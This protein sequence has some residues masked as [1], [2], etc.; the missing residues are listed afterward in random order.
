MKHAISRSLEKYGVSSELFKKSGWEIREIRVWRFGGMILTGK[1]KYWEKNIIQRGG[2]WMNEYGALVEWYWLTGGTE[3]LAEK[4]YTASVV[5]EWMS[6]QNWWNDTDR[7]NW[8]TGRKTLYSVGDRWMNEYGAL[9]EW[10]WQGKNEVI[11][12]KHYTASVVDEWMSMGHWW[13]DTDRGK[14]K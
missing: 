8:S 4:H 7:G 14:L 1:L 2:R 3:V 13:N 11:G 5:D 12:A 10:Y 9:V 6:M